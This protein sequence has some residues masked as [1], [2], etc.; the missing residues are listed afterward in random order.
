VT[1][2]DELGAIEK[3]A[4]AQVVAE[5]TA[6]EIERRYLEEL[7]ALRAG[8]NAKLRPIAEEREARILEA[9]AALKAAR[10]GLP[11]PTPFQMADEDEGGPARRRNARVAALAAA[12]KS[13]IAARDRAADRYST[14]A[15]KFRGEL[16]AAETKLGAHFASLSARAATRSAA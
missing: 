9:A 8:F 15:A 12:E 6:R 11:N 10:A 14:A 13:F 5:R 2:V 7:I 3:Q 1:T 4:L 16:E